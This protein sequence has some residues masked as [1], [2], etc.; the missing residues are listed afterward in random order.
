MHVSISPRRLALGLAAAAAIAL[1]PSLVAAQ[2]VP[3]TQWKATLRGTSEVP[4][5]TSTATGDFTATLDETN[6]T[7][8][9]VLN[10][11]NITNATMAHL[12]QGAPGVNGPVVLDLWIPALAQPSAN[13][14]NTSSTSRTS[15]LKG[16][17]ENN[18]AAF[19][20]AL[21]AGNIYV[22]VHT[23]ANPGGEIRGQV[24]SASA[25]ATP[26][27]TGTATATATVSPTATATSTPI[28]TATATASPAAT[29]TVRPGSTGATAP[30]PAKTGTGGLSSSASTSIALVVAL[31]TVAGVGTFAARRATRGR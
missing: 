10:V 7:I 8:S 16:G 1:A 25:T 2:T 6:Q 22:N 31:M 11:P 26:T 18:F 15:N 24:V 12:H 13:T 5:N 28:A 17:L 9:W 14:I 19:A 21:K 27:A 30:A 23:T 29:A 4:A 20:A 3:T